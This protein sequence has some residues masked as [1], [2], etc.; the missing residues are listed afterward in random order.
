MARSRHELAAAM[1][2]AL[3]LVLLRSNLT[4]VLYVFQRVESLSNTFVFLGLWAYLRLRL[5][6][7]RGVDAAFGW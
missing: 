3:W 7:W 5:L 2:T 4:G 1:L 6:D